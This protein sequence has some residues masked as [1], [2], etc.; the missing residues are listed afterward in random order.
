MELGYVILNHRGT[1]TLE[2]GVKLSEKE[3]HVL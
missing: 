2:H 1:L 3:D